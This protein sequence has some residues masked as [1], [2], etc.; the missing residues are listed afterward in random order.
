MAVARCHVLVLTADGGTFSA[1][2]GCYGKLGHGDAQDRARLVRVQALHELA[3]HA[4]AAGQDHSL[5]T[6][7]DGRVFGFGRRASLG[8]GHAVAL[9]IG[10][11]PSDEECAFLPTEVRAGGRC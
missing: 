4:V 11:T 7:R 6:A 9:G 5:A 10:H 1:G 2:N 3:V 8:L